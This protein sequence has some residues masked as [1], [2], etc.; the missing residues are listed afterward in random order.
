MRQ[1]EDEEIIVEAKIKKKKIKEKKRIGFFKL[2]YLKK[3]IFLLVDLL[4]NRFHM[5][6]IEDVLKR[7]MLVLVDQPEDNNQQ[8]HKYP[9]E[10]NNSVDVDL[11]PS[12]IEFEDVVQIHKQ[13]VMELLLNYQL[14]ND[15]E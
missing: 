9:R 6:I 14:I 15:Q 2:F 5:E 7:E 11:R 10:E 1:E 13:T 4:L 3:R 12:M 8:K